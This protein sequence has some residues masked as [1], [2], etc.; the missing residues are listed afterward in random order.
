MIDGLKATE[1]E[2]DWLLKAIEKTTQLDP[3]QLDELAQSL[4]EFVRQSDVRFLPRLID[5]LDRLARTPPVFERRHCE[6]STR[7]LWVLKPAGIAVE[8]LLQD[9][10]DAAFNP[11]TMSLLRSIPVAQS[12]YG[13]S[14]G[15]DKLKLD[16]LVTAWPELNLA[17]FWSHIEA[18]RQDPDRKPEQRVAS[19]WDVHAWPFFVKHATLSLVALIEAAR[20][21]PV[22]DDRLAAMDMACRLW[23]EGGK[24]KAI[25]K[26][27]REAATVPELDALLAGFV[28]PPPPSKEMRANERSIRDH[29]RRM[30]HRQKQVDRNTAKWRAHLTGNLQ[31]IRSPRFKDPGAVSQEQWYLYERLRWK[32]GSPTRRGE[33]NWTKLI[34]EFGEEAAQAFRDGAVAFWRKHRP[35][36]R[37]NGAEP[38][39][40]PCAALIGLAGLAIETRGTADW[41]ETIIP[42]EA[43]T[44][45]A[46]AMH[47]INGFPDWLPGLVDRF[48]DQ[49][50]PLILQEIEHEL[51]VETEGQNSH[52]ILSDLVWRGD[53]SWIHI[54]EPVFDI[55]SSRRTTNV[56]SLR[57]LT[58]IV[59]GSTLAGDR[60]AELAAASLS[61][62]TRPAHRA[63][64]HAVWTATDPQRAIPALEQELAS[65]ND[66]EAETRYAMRFITDLVGGRR[67]EP[68]RMRPAF[69]TPEHLLALYTLMHR[70]RHR[71][72]REGR[73]FAGNAR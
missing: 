60:I 31:A 8:R 28:N 13:Y 34:P 63:H 19:W 49:L 68:S 32:D 26:A 16:E 48:P 43:C 4:A 5:G 50:V 7:Y 65:L 25:L 47:E 27:L 46:Y 45:F 52:Y 44:A 18:A 59:Q 53:W 22:L 3:H 51:S 56:A 1:A 23:L 21:R 42:E 17:L 36:T 66:H 39:T 6:V 58:A 38:N 57:R 9:R 12:V 73:V 41:R 15:D 62:E 70:Y 67:G 10:H 71:A 14:V 11:A 72:R 35:K 2:V 64:W 33:A 40:T 20:S 29:K 54:A 61:T 37:A 24:P 55:L 69:R 30:K